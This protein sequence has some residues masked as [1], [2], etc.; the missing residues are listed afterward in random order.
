MFRFSS[1]P[2]TRTTPGTDGLDPALIDAAIER[3]VT[4]TD[5]RLRALGDYRKRLEEPVACAVRHVIDLVDQLPAP[6]EISP[7]AFGSDARVRAFFSSGDHV[8]EALSPQPMP[9]IARLPGA[10]PGRACR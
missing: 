7:P 4:G 1:S 6:A 8:R 5:R 10:R 9:R 3:A 2:F